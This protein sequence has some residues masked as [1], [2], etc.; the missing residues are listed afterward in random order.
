MPDRIHEKLIQRHLGQ[1]SR[2]RATLRPGEDPA[3]QK[4][5]PVVTISRQAG[6]GSREL[7]ETLG[8]RLDLQVFGKEI[9]EHIARDEHLTRE[10]VAAL[11]ERVASQ[12]EQWVRGM[13]DRRFFLQDD[14]HLALVRVVRTLAAHGGVILL[15]RGANFVLADRVDLR[16][17]LVASE[18]WR[19]QNLA[20]RHQLSADDARAT[21]RE[22]E[23]Q[24]AAFVR[25]LFHTE[26]DDPRHYDLV[27]NVARLGP[28]LPEVITAA[29]AH[30]EA[31]TLAAEARD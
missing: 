9:V 15:G 3:Q 19:V 29:L 25:R 22:L 27:L 5:L 17:R 31:S 4:A 30:R 11:D 6:C 1:W 23:N 7:A 20:V 21:V 13:L 10:V 8:Q 2:L 24:R 28:A 16:V 12:I 18:E 14:Y 26:V